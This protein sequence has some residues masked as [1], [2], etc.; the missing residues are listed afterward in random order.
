ML[1][2][3]TIGTVLIGSFIA[4]SVEVTEMVIIVVGVGTTRGWRSTLVGAGCGLILLVGLIGGMGRALAHVPINPLRVAI[5]A[6]PLT[7]GLQ[8][9]TTG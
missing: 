8:W 1:G 6:L 5:G 4:C 3:L 7:F 9:L 2:T